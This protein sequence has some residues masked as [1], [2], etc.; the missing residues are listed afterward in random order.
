MSSSVTIHLWLLA[1]MG[2]F[3]GLYSKELQRLI[4]WKDKRWNQQIP[5]Y[6]AKITGYQKL[7]AEKNDKPGIQTWRFTAADSQVLWMQNEEE[8]VREWER[9]RES[10]QYVSDLKIL[11]SIKSNASTWGGKSTSSRALGTKLS[12]CSKLF[13][14]QPRGFFW[15]W[16]YWFWFSC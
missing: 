1:R 15:W 12:C 2:S 11:C 6:W 5:T 10:R 9:E 8:L 16:R 7:G 14:R 3:L 4:R 13:S